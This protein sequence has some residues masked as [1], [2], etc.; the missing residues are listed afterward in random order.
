MPVDWKE[1][2]RGLISGQ[3]FSNRLLELDT[4]TAP[5]RLPPDVM[6]IVL[7]YCPMG[8]VLTSAALVCRSWRGMA[9]RSGVWDSFVLSTLVRITS[10]PAV[11]PFLVTSLTPSQIREQFW[12]GQLPQLYAGCRHINLSSATRLSARYISQGVGTCLG[13]VSL[14]FSMSNIDDAMVKAMLDVPTSCLQGLTHLTLSVC[15]GVTQEGIVPLIE[16]CPKLEVLALGHLAGVCGGAVC[17]AVSKSCTSIRVLRFHGLTFRMPASFAVSASL[18]ELDL[19]H[20]TLPGVVLEGLTSMFP[21]LSRLTIGY[22]SGLSDGGFTAMLRRGGASLT[23]L[24]ASGSSLGTSLGTLPML[25]PQLRQLLLTR[26]L[27]TGVEVTA[28]IEGSPCLERID[29]AQCVGARRDLAR[30]TLQQWVRDRPSLL[31]DATLAYYGFPT[32]TS[33]QGC[34]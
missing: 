14:D 10:M 32:A 21:A 26:T 31:S 28:V 3:Q 16:A 34:M 11:S 9:A 8:E 33:R 27:V 13:V 25:A 12:L 19:T 18:Q 17:Q 15:E 22:V 6:C 4:K 2:H 24:D 7:S 30:G 23:H 29:F 20:S 5:W 1:I